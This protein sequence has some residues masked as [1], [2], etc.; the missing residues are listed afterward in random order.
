MVALLIFLLV[1]IIAGVIIY[2]LP[3]Y[4]LPNWVKRLIT[5]FYL[6]F[7]L[8]VGVANLGTVVGWECLVSPGA[9]IYISAIFVG[10]VSLIAIS[11]VMHWYL[12]RSR[13][14]LRLICHE[15]V[16]LLRR[17]DVIVTQQIEEAIRQGGIG[18][19]P[20]SSLLAIMKAAVNA[21]VCEA[22][23]DAGGPLEASD[24]CGSTRNSQRGSSLQN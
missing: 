11:F 6:V 7:V 20:P 24:P 13:V 5:G 18:K 23:M 3:D 21:G 12:F 17:H 16:E 4:M 2:F 22:R 14:V 9:L 15:V 1:V 19:V 8:V 10:L